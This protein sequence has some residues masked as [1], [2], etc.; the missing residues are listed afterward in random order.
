M[1]NDWWSCAVMPMMRLEGASEIERLLGEWLVLKCSDSTAVCFER[2][3]L[4]S[5]VSVFMR[6]GWFSSSFC[7]L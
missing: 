5:S 7:A 1:G 4:K 6:N 2:V 3:F